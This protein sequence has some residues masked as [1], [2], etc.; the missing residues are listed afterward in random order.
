V[1]G[2][3]GAAR[4]LS[5]YAPGG[6]LINPFACAEPNNANSRSRL[7]LRNSAILKNTYSIE[8]LSDELS[9]IIVSIST[10]NIQLA[11]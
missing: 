1:P 4:A 8:H 6:L 10:Q 9:L 3:T 2:A 5:R 11:L 7:L